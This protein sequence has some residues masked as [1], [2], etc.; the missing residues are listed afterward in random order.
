[1]KEKKCCICR[2]SFSMHELLPLEL[3]RPSIFGIIKEKYPKTTYED[4]ICTK[5]YA[6]F[7][8]TYHKKNI[9]KD[10]QL[11]EA[12]LFVLETMADKELLSTNTIDTFEEQMTLGERIADKVSAFG[13]SW[14]F[15]MLF[16]VV[17]VAWMAIN[18]L[19]VLKEAFDPYPYILLNLCLSCLA[20]MQ[21]PI[22]MMSQNRRSDL[23]RIKAEEDYK[24]NLHSE[25]IL[26]HLNAKLDRFMVSQWNQ[27][28]EICK[29]QKE[30]HVLLNSKTNTPEQDL[31]KKEKPRKD[32][33]ESI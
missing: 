21:A 33:E 7:K 3:V 15:I 14:P 28:D 11:T 2:N 17:M 6:S 30:L 13:G 9:A 20:A 24:V 12:D 29:T 23:D 8:T 16:I 32:D 27:L 31:S 1:M 26:K 18:S 4:F 25:L 22:I 19:D 5:D 10:H